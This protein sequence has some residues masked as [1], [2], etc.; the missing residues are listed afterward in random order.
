M[1][2]ALWNLTFQQSNRE[3]RD[4][5][6]LFRKPIRGAQQDTRWPHMSPLTPHDLFSPRTDL[7]GTEVRGFNR[8]T[9]DLWV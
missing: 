5:E 2:L 9:G 6:D 8:S 7:L 3:D 1:S 4:E